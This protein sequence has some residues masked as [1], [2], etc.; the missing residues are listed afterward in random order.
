MSAAK[1]KSVNEPEET[2]DDE[3][4]ETDPVEE[5]TIDPPDNV[6]RLPLHTVADREGNIKVKRGR[7]RPKTVSRKPDIS[8]LEYHAQ[9]SEE[10]KRFI[11]LDPVVGVT[12]N[13]K[14]P[15]EVLRMISME[16]AKEQAALNFQRIEHEKLGKDT[17]Q[18]SSRRVEALAKI[19]G[20]ELDMKKLGTDNIDFSSEKFQKVFSL[21]VETLREVAEEVL[22]AKE[23]DLFFNRFSTKMEGWE[24]RAANLTR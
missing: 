1:E 6:R 21:W 15:I 18:V 24:E 14:E 7:G 8:D 4:D 10:K 13:R 17:A 2:Q 22:Q 5:V 16:I 12:K 11:E 9:M 23:I 3:I 19:A 20:I